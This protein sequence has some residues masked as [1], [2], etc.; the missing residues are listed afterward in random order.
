[1]YQCTKDIG[2]TAYS[3]LNSSNSRYLDSEEPNLNYVRLITQIKDEKDKIILSTKTK[4]KAEK[5]VKKLNDELMNDSRTSI[6][7]WSIKVQ[8]TNEEGIQPV[9]FNNDEQGI[10]TYTY[11]VPY[12]KECNN[13][14]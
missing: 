13:I 8:F 7:H 10:P 11:S 12:I 1:M 6:T 14:T 3:I 2:Y 4:L 5:L 9:N